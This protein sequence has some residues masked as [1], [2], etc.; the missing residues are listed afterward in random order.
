M[1]ASEL[2]AFHIS[3]SPQPNAEGQVLH[4]ELLTEGFGNSCAVVLSLV[5][6]QGPRSV[7]DQQ[8]LI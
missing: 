2:L 7:P 1:S 6:K 8:G 4:K 5:N 3:F